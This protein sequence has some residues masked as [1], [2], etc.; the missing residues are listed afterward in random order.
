LIGTQSDGKGCS[1][2]GQAGHFDRAAVRVHNGFGNGQPESSTSGRT[3]ARFVGAI[4]TLKDVR[5]VFEKD[6]QIE[7]S[8][9]W[10]NASRPTA[11]LWKN[12]WPGKASPAGR[13]LHPSSSLI[14]NLESVLR[15]LAG[16]IGNSRRDVMVEEQ[17]QHV[18]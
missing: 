6:A 10:S 18:C 11:P 13:M 2:A 8:P 9:A 15:M 12:S 14:L 3:R 17:P 5:E 1:C 4:K 16:R 7:Y